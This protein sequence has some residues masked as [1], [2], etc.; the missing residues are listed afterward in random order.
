MKHTIGILGGMG[1][2][3]TADMLEKF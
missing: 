3:A 2:A 1:P